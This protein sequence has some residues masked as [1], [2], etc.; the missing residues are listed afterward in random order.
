MKP[1]IGLVLS[2]VMLCIAESNEQRMFA[3]ACALLCVLLLGLR[4]TEDSANTIAALDQRKL[5]MGV[6][7]LSLLPLTWWL[8]TFAGAP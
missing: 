2:A 3:G 8:S 7:W 4:K 6:M 5:L 1:V